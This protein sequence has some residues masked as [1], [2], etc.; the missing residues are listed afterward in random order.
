MKT[1]FSQLRD[2]CS[3]LLYRLGIGHY[4]YSQDLTRRLLLE[5]FLSLSAT[6]LG[7]GILEVFCAFFFASYKGWR[8]V[9]FLSDFIRLCSA[10]PLLS[11]IHI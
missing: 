11:L 2:W 1:R 10:A 8:N 6:L 5:Y 3:D 4:S 9:P 7:L